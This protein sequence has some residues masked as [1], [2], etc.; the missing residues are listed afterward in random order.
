MS[1][2]TK[3]VTNPLGLVGFA[4]FL[5]FGYL[6]KV[7][8]S[9]ERRW[10]SPVAICLAAAALIGGIAIAYLQIPKAGQAPAR[11]GQPLPPAKQR[12]NQQVQQTSTG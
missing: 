9:D 8:K 2:W 4:L 7:K 12:S 5:V 6:A 11:T 3:V 1:E 10:I